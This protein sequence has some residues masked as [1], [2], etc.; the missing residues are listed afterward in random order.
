MGETLYPQSSLNRSVLIIGDMTGDWHIATAQPAA[1]AWFNGSTVHISTQAGGSALLAKLLQCLSDSIPA[2]SQIHYHMIAPQ[3]ALPT[4]SPALPQVYARFSLFP[5]AKVGTDDLRNRK[6]WRIIE[7]LGTSPAVQPSDVAQIT[8]SAQPDVILIDDHNLGFRNNPPTCLDVLKDKKELPWVILKTSSP[9]VSGALWEQLQANSA[10]QLIVLTSADELRQSDV[11]ISREISW[12]RTAQD[13]AWELVYNPQVNALSRCAAVVVTLGTSGVFLL[14]RGE[15][16]HYRLFFDPTATEGSWVMDYPGKIWGYQSCLAASIAHVIASGDGFAGLPAAIQGGIA[17]LR[18]LHIQG[19]QS[20]QAE[21]G[22][23]VLSFPISQVARKIISASQAAQ[24]ANHPSERKKSGLLMEIDVQDPMVFLRS[25]K[26]KEDSHPQSGDWSILHTAHAENLSDLAQQVVLKGLEAVLVDVPFGRFGKLLTVDRKEIES[27]R[28]IRALVSEYAQSK[29]HRP[30]SIAVF[31]SPGSGKSFGVKQVAKALLEDQI[32]ILEFNLSQ[33]HGSADLYD[34]FHQIRDKALGGK[35]PLVFWDE[36]DSSLESTRLGWLRYFLVPM[37]DGAFQQGQLTH[38][39]GRC[40]FVFAGGTSHSMEQFGKGLDPGDPVRS[41]ELFRTVK[42]PDFVSRL[43]G[44]VNVLGPNP[45]E[46]ADSG[47]DPYYILRRAILFRSLLAQHAPQLF[48]KGGG[49]GRLI[50]DSGVVRAFLQ[51]RLYRHGARSMEALILTSHLAGKLKYERSSLPSE[52]QL[53]MH[54]NAQD[55]LALLQQIQLQGEVLE[56]MADAAHQI[57]CETIQQNGIR[58]GE[59]CSD[60]AESSTVLVPFQQLPEEIQQQNRANV[61]DIPGKIARFGYSM[62]HA[63]NNEPIYEF[64]GDDLD[65]M[66]R[67]EHDR[68]MQAKLAAGWRFGPRSNEERTNPCLVQ[69]EDLD[70][71]EKE[72]D[73]EL[74]RQIPRIL[75]RVGYAVLPRKP[76]T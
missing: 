70:E 45:Q 61:V 69:W 23:Q 59:T 44:F 75:A 47:E 46:S 38:P 67:E 58:Y 10:E 27:F 50:I 18:E 52:E 54:V 40:I 25:S 37:Q 9:V 62:V 53:K 35:M 65:K 39:I 17:G 15:V 24:Q 63:R 66:A 55:F 11:Q 42:G 32:E 72:K 68:W 34:C 12:E 48:D 71:S 56:R 57:Y 74:V 64:P 51:T 73:R 49:T 30:L 6:S 33:L 2:S 4:N 36:F 7:F 3:V 5:T 13:L 76:I 1:N 31:G 20:W 60:Q 41:A 26:P 29:E 14:T 43:K 21:S 16:P 28:N 22:A 19:Y 8:A